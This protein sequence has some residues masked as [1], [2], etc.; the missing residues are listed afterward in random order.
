MCT[1]LGT[2]ISPTKAP[3]KMIFLFPRW[4]ML[5]PCRIGG[6]KN[7]FSE[8]S[9][10]KIS[11]LLRWSVGAHWHSLERHGDKRCGKL[12]GTSDLNCI[13]FVMYPIYLKIHL[14]LCG[15]LNLIFSID[16]FLY[17]FICYFCIFIAESNEFCYQCISLTG[18]QADSSCRF[19]GLHP[20]PC[21]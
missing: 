2:N 14:V 11:M 8:V 20:R 3:L 18:P 7:L 9:C 1:L 21:V 13:E 4:D 15:K 16:V 17:F 12:W 5:V 19:L 10:C 6:C